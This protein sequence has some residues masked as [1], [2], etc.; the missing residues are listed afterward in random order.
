MSRPVLALALACV[1][2]TAVA[3]AAPLRRFALVVG[4]DEGGAGTRPLRFARD[5]ARKMHALL[6]RLGGVE[7]HDARLLLDA[8]ADS[9]LEAMRG[10]EQEIARAA[11]E[12]RR[13]LL[14]V[15]YSGHAKDGELRLGNSRLPLSRLK[16]SLLA[17]GADVRIGIVDA[18]RSGEVTRTKGARR[19]P[20]FDIDTGQ[21]AAARGTVLLTSSAADEDSQ[22]S[23]LLGG[24]FFTHHLVSGLL[25][26]ADRSGE[27][28]VSLA[29]A[30]AYA[31]QRT[32]A[33]TA[34]SAAGAQHPTFHFDLAGNGDI[35][36]TDVAGRKDGLTLPAGAPAGPYFL[37][38]RAGLV[39]AEIHKPEGVERR[40]AL[41]PGRYRVKRRLGDR[42]R[43]GEVDV[44]QGRLTRLDEASLRDAPFSDDPVKGVTQRLQ[45]WAFSVTAGAQ[46]FFD[47][48]TRDSLFPTL[49]LLGA[50]AEL[51]GFLRRDWVWG[52]DV[53]AGGVDGTLR[54]EGL[55]PLRYR[56]SQLT[57]GSTILVEFPFG[58]LVPYGG[59]RLSLLVLG[60]EFED[61]GSAPAVVQHRVPGTGRRAQGEARRVVEPVDP[62][63]RAVRALQRGCGPL[64]RLCRSGGDG[65]VCALSSV[66]GRAA[67]APPSRSAVSTLLLRRVR[68][69][70]LQRGPA[71]HR[72][73]SG[74][75]GAGG[76][77]ARADGTAGTGPAD[78][79]GH[80]GRGPRASSRRGTWTRGG[81]ARA[82]TTAVH[83]L[84]RLLEHVRRIAA[85]HAG[86]GEAD[87]GTLRARGSARLR[88][89]GGDVA[90]RRRWTPTPGPSSSG[91]GSVARRGCR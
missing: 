2:G 45:H 11:R 80:P 20:T 31:Y 70:L 41:V 64:A 44:V 38:D 25:G 1:L 40:V 58:A 76:A 24:S 34:D 56:V 36:L 54:L 10:L 28:R 37:V 27:G 39:A 55:S 53:A 14:L 91:A 82:S 9:V 43:I 62:G 63:A 83:A 77:R 81:P 33:D 32:V 87:L 8:P 4:N 59:G 29:E 71:L 84:L 89:P 5:D 3:E 50:E 26:D 86:A 18:C 72:R 57:L 60:R 30:Y 15:Y 88:G 52:F 74:S 23:D 35:T 90:R 46:S 48:P 75:G 66:A 47:A 51:A 65:D 6:L 79:N 68:R 17:S 61:S 49:G 69:Q 67:C 85:H 73:P 21:E 78:G 22:E 42:L 19:A 12:G 13:T 7:A 16:S